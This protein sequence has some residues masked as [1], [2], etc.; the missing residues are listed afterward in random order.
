MV[1]DPLI[2][3]LM[4]VRNEERHIEQAVRS[5]LDNGYPPEK[6]ELIVIDGQ[7]DDRTR[8]ILAEMAKDAP[9]RILDNPKRIVPTAMNIGLAKAGGEL[10]FRLDGHAMYRPGFLRRIVD[11]LAERPDVACAGGVLETIG[12]TPMARAITAAQ[13]SPFGVGDSRFRLAGYTGAVDTVAFGGYRREVFERIGGFDEE[14]VRNQ[15]DELNHRLL[16]AGMRIWMLG[17]VG[18]VYVA[19]ST[20]KQLG[21]Q[22]FQYGF[23]KIRTMQ[24]L[25]R[26]PT[27]RALVPLLFTGTL[28][29]SLIFAPWTAWPLLV[30]GLAYGSFL[31]AG[32]VHGA[33]QDGL[34]RLRKVAAI[35]VLHLSYGA[36]GWTGILKFC[37]GWRA[38]REQVELSR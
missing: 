28:A 4:P 24:K 15:D 6:I 7:S 12:T 1:H 2:T 27:L 25:G 10:I 33:N 3:V 21:R 36:G 18:S 26:V 8:E 37:L 29:A 13:T 9:I 34:L 16:K 31:L 30:L 23:W 5:V 11:F 22:Y 35:V 17:E 19:R 20:L 38:I 32:L 14:L